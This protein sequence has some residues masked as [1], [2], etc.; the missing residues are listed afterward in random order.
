MRLY[1][2]PVTVT[3]SPPPL[4]G[5]GRQPLAVSSA[6][7]VVLWETG[8]EAAD[9]MP[10]LSAALAATFA[11]GSQGKGTLCLT[12]NARPIDGLPG[13]SPLPPGWVWPPEQLRR[14][15]FRYCAHWR[16]LLDAF[17]LGM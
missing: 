12:R 14:A 16:K 8:D 9:A 3:V 4:V 15:D 7:V 13:D 6:R 1:L 17:P 2:L 5:H 11:L 10:D